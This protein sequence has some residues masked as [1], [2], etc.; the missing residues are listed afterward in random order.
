MVILTDEFETMQKVAVL[1][2]TT[3]CPERLE[4]THQTLIS[5]E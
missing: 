3:I 5:P 4:K 2:Y 1:N